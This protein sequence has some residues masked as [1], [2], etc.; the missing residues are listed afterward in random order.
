MQQIMFIVEI[1][2]NDAMSTEPIYS[3]A[4]RNFSKAVA[5]KTAPTK[6][7]RQLH[8]GAWLLDVNGALPWLNAVVDE[9]L[10][11]QFAYSVFLISGDVIEMTSPDTSFNPP[12]PF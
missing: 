11:A 4:W 1:P 6:G 2:P 8:E 7:W 5:A 9:V 3:F 10:A 12:L